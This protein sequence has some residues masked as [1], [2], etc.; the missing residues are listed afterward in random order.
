MLFWLFERL[1]GRGFAI[2][3]TFTLAR[4]AQTKDHPDHWFARACSKER[5][6]KYTLP[7]LAKLQ[8]V[9]TTAVEVA[10]RL[11]INVNKF[12]YKQI[13][14]GINAVRW[15]VTA[16]EVSHDQPGQSRERYFAWLC[17]NEQQLAL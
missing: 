12:I 6:A 7:Y 14:K 8:E 5:W 10:R 3:I 9:A 4:E 11:R 13:W 2:D 15:A 1:R 16:E 17:V